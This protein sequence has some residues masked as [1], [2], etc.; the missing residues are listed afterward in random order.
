MYNAFETNTYREPFRKYTFEELDAM[1][2]E[3]LRYIYESAKARKYGLE[4]E[5]SHLNKMV[6]DCKL[7]FDGFIARKKKLMDEII[8]CIVIWVIIGIGVN[9]ID[10]LGIAFFMSGI[11]FAMGLINLA[12]LCVGIYKI[13]KYRKEYKKSGDSVRNTRNSS[14]MQQKEYEMMEYASKASKVKIEMDDV[15]DLII[16]LERRLA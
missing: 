11:Q 4:R 12:V 5:Y 1:G 14:L 8:A 10:R 2:T 15:D 3:E 6:D 9:L 7:S 16:D 13:I